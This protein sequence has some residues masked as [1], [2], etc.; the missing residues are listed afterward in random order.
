MLPARRAA[1]MDMWNAL[2]ANDKGKDKMPSGFEA[3]VNGG[4]RRA[5]GKGRYH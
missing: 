1:I 4:S 3:R 5:N 2:V